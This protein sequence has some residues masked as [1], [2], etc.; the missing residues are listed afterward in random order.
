MSLKSNHQQLTSKINQALSNQD[1]T[2]NIV[3]ELSK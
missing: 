3:N 2:S 1:N